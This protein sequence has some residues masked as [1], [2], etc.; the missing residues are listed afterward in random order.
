MFSELEDIEEFSDIIREEMIRAIGTLDNCILNQPE[1]ALGQT[2]IEIEQAITHI[3]AAMR[4]L[5]ELEN[6]VMEIKTIFTAARKK[7]KKK[8]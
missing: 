8:H 5:D 2:A 1:S 4:N 7:N 6:Q 3:T